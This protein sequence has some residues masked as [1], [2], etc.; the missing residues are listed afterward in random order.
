MTIGVYM[1]PRRVMATARIDLDEP[2]GAA[3]LSQG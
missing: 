3:L 2:A 1:M